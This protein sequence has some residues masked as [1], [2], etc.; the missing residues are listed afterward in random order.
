M[1]S[2]SAM[3]YPAPA[4]VRVET[5]WSDV[6]AATGAAVYR[7][8]CLTGER[9]PLRPYVSFDGD[10]LD[11]SCG[12]GI[13]WDTEA[14]L[15]RCVYYCTQAQN[16]SGSTVTQPAP[17]LF[18]DTFTRN[19][20]NGWGTSDSGLPYATVGGV[21]SDYSV[22]GSFGR[23]LASTS[24]RRATVVGAPRDWVNVQI[25]GTVLPT[26]SATGAP[27]DMGFLLRATN[28]PDTA[29]EGLVRFNPSGFMDARI[30]QQ[31]N[32][33]GSNLASTTSVGIWPNSGVAVRVKFQAWGTALRVKVWD[34]TLPEPTDW[35]VSWD[36]GTIAQAAGAGAVLRVQAGNTNLPFTGSFDN[37]V[38]TDLCA[39]PI[40][41]EQCSDSLVV[42]SSGDFRLGDPVRPCNDVV[43]QMVGEVGPD[44]VPTQGIFF[45]NMADE[46]S[47][48]NTA[49]FQPVNAEFPITANRTR[50]G[51]TSTLTVASRTFADRD[52]LRALN[53]PGGA[54]LIRGPVAYG[55]S[56]RYMSV[57]DTSESRPMAD[58]K[59]Q[60]RVVTMPHTQ[61][62]RPSGPSQGVCGTRVADLCDRYATWDA[63][64]VA[65]LN[66]TDLLRGRAST[67]TPKPVTV[68]Q[69]W[70]DVNAQYGNW[71][72]VNSGNVDWDDLRDGA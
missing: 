25:E 39:D 41:I 58:H 51:L 49:A 33:V 8:D 48:A 66:Y 46:T 22:N 40:P 2:I 16:A 63:M 12:Y 52:A 4:Y 57:G 72:A 27:I 28:S 30:N 45:G 10:F 13:F 64:V 17:Y 14:P 15:D 44:C 3:V 20:S 65:G 18:T 42:P 38:I 43:L 68:E 23:I 21:A 50:S 37:I 55:V 61:V 7:V 34:L 9:V 59:I 67:D 60:P 32:G 62:A 6:S 56:D 35:Q 54:L 71:N 47:G 19:T 1:P 53:K 70:N 36:D 31:L 5:N 11:L 26:V 24:V 29:Y 69:T